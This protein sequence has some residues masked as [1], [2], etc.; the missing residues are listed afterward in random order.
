MPP[1]PTFNSGW[2]NDS[3]PIVNVNWDD[4]QSYCQWAGGRLPS[5]AEWEY[6]ARGGSPEARYGSLDEVAWYG[7]N[8]G[9]QTQP[10][11]KKRA[12][13]FGLYDVL[14]NV[15]EWVSDW[16][17]QNYYQNSPSQDPTGPTS[18]TRR[19]RRVLRGGSWS[20]GPGSVR[21]SFRSRYVPGRAYDV[22]FRC[23]G[24]VFAP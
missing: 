14:G 11:G 5:E 8:S 6:A 1:A 10:V 18:R 9:K 7:E 24:E 20:F 19:A 12:N 21:V 22:G 23:G 3:M 15:Y 2:V 16:C 4:A 13:G 17:D